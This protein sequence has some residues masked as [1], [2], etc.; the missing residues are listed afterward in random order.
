[1]TLKSKKDFDIVYK[2]PKKWHNPHF[3]LFFKEN[4]KSSRVGFCVSKKVGNAVCRNLIKRRLRSL[5]RDS[6]ANLISGDMI[7]LAKSGLDKTPYA[8]LQSS[9]NRA[10]MCLK[11]VQTKLTQATIQTGLAP[12]C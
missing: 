5:Y 6:M 2:S 9:Y 4:P 10:L 12:K 1:M 7:L 8:V 3:I 11:L